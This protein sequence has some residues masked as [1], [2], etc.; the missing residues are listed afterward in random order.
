MFFILVEVLVVEVDVV[1]VVVEGVVV[2]LT[3]E[4]D[5][6]FNKKIPAKTPIIITITAT[7]PIIN[8]LFI[9]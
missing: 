8:S 2:G 5:L 6:W 1:S 3:T 9:I 4:D 7:I